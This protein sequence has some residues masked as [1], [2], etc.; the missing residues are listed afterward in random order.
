MGVDEAGY[1]TAARKI[2]Q[3]H[4]TLE[5]L[6]NDVDLKPNQRIAVEHYEDFIKHIPRAEVTK[7]G[8][9]VRKALHEVDS[10][11]LQP[12]YTSLG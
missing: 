5:D 7:T 3:G 8:Q 12:Q 9:I 6:K 1:P 11:H 10:R 2:A 4:R